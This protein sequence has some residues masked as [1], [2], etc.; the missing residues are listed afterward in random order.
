MR[1]RLLMSV[2]GALL[3]NAVVCCVGCNREPEGMTRP[4]P[5][6]GTHLG[7]VAGPEFK[8]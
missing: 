6:A 8:P 4:A 3:L 5:P 7:K 1:R 2:A